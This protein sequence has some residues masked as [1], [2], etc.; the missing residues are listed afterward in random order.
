VTEVRTEHA[1]GTVTVKTTTTHPDGTQ[2]IEET[3]T[4]LGVPDEQAPGVPDDI[5]SMPKAQ[6]G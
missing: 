2:T 4:M 5:E 1:D 6:V 3:T